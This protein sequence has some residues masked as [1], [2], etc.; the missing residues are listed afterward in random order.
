MANTWVDSRLPRHSTH[1]PPNM[2]YNVPNEGKGM[3]EKEKIAHVL[4]RFGLGAGKVELAKYEK[5]GLQGTL[6]A[7]ID[8][9]KVEEGFP[10]GPWEFCK[11]PDG[12]LQFDPYKFSSWWGLR[13]LLTN[14]PLQEQ[15]T[16][17]WHN[18]F[19]VSGAKVFDG[20]A[21]VT[22]QNCLRRNAAGNFRK[23]LKEVSVEPAMLYWLDQNT[24][25]KEHPNENFAR[26]VMELF[27]MGSG[28]TEKD[29]KEAARAFTGWS[30]NVEAFGENIEFYIQQERA[31]RA[32]RSPFNYCYVPA[33]HDDG[34]KT[35]LGKTGNFSGDQALDILCDRPETARFMAKKLWEWFAYPNPELKLVESLAKTFIDNKLEIKPVIRAIAAAPEFWSEKCVRAKV[36]SPIDFTVAT[37]RQ[38]GLQP[39]ILALRGE[40]KDI[41][42]PLK[43]EVRGAADGVTYLMN[44]QGFLLNFPPD[45]SGWNWGEA[46]I[47]SNN[48]RIRAQQAD[49]MFWGGDA[50]RPIA[51]YLANK[52]KQEK[53]P[54]TA[55]DVVDAIC[56][57]FDATLPAKSRETLIEGCAK[58]GGPLALNNK[59][60]AAGVFATVCKLIFASPEFQ[61]C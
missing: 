23:L 54:Q 31:A 48:M 57:I 25:V 50:N 28:Y 1:I 42:Q 45:V 53:N 2:P 22:Y 16:L 35:I 32:G 33:V 11:Q 4:R 7:L 36:K 21:M 30:L 10:V 18:H 34:P 14:R 39:T 60:S 51:V 44:A 12:Q 43:T 13:L 47:N 9:D 40:V 58:A 38:L 15:L 24:S 46:W 3:T 27:T 6:N 5:L 61:L 20:T 26:E 29:I 59:D 19:A 55:A 37:F 56:E 49:V 17:F 41:F 52:I 8:Y